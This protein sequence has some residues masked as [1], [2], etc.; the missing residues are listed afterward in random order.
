MSQAFEEV[1]SHYVGLYQECAN[2]YMDEMGDIEIFP[3]TKLAT[4]TEE[5]QVRH[6]LNEVQREHQDRLGR[7]GLA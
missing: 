5:D 7:L 6:L 2:Q 3:G 4:V 1:I